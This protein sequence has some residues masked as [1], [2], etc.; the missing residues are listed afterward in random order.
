MHFYIFCVK[1]QDSTNAL[2][3]LKQRTVNL[4]DGVYLFSRAVSSQ[5]F[6]TLMSLT[7]VF[8]MGT[9]GSSPPSTPS[10]LRFLFRIA[11]LKDTCKISSKPNNNLPKVNL[12]LS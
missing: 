2:S 9:G 12:S 8:G 4:C 1:N 6:S 11:F 3:R 5:V 10:L 7:S